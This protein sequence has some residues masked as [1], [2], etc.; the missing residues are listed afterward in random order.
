MLKFLYGFGSVDF[1]VESIFENK[2]KQLF[3]DFL[4][5]LQAGEDTERLCV[6]SC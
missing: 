5:L 1:L 6:F 2:L 3:L 4:S